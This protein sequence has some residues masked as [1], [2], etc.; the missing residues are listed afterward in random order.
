MN[1]DDAEVHPSAHILT[2]AVGV[3]RHLKL[4]LGYC[5]ALTGDRYLLCTDGVYG[6][7]SDQDLLS[8]LMLEAREEAVQGLIESALTHGGRDNITAII[9]DLTEDANKSA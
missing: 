3:H 6:M 2:R 1:Q 9:V 4:E 5:P 7:I 8:Q